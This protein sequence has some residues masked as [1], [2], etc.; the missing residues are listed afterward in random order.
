MLMV[1]PCWSC[2]PDQIN[3]PHT[4]FQCALQTTDRLIVPKPLNFPQ[5]MPSESTGK[6]PSN[7][8]THYHY[9]LSYPITQNSPILTQPKVFKTFDANRKRLC[10][11][12]EVQKRGRK[13][14]P[15][16]LIPLSQNAYV[17]RHGS[18]MVSMV[19]WVYWASLGSMDESAFLERPD[20]KAKNI[21]V[22][23]ASWSV[24]ERWFVACLKGS[25]HPND[26]GREGE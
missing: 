4:R 15:S 22:W 2:V 3:V 11:S 21:V 16:M 10:G 18:C 1:D 13:G 23:R 8:T 26:R 24:G 19:W 25:R 17:G 7:H 12:E 6:Y 20:I 9:L 5:P 14:K